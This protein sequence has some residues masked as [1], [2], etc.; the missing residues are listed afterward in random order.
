MATVL[1]S[2]G[3]NSNHTELGVASEESKWPFVTLPSFSSWAGGGVGGWNIQ[4]LR[5]LQDDI[6]SQT[7]LLTI[8]S[9][10][11]GVIVPHNQLDSWNGYSSQLA[12]KYV[13]QELNSQQSMSDSSAAHQAA[14]DAAAVSNITPYVWNYEAGDLD[15]GIHDNMGNSTEKVEDRGPASEYAVSWQSTPLQPGAINYNDLASP[16]F[17]L[18]YQAMQESSKSSLSEIILSAPI[19]SDIETTPLKPYSLLLQPIFGSIV[20]DGKKIVGYLKAVVSWEA[21][22]HGI[23]PDG[24]AGIRV[25]VDSGACRTGSLTSDEE[26]KSI[27]F[28]LDGENA[29]MLGAGDSHA[30]HGSDTLLFQTHLGSSPSSPSQSSTSSILSSV[31]EKQGCAY[32]IM[33]YST[34]EFRQGYI[35]QRPIW[36]ALVG[37]STVVLTA[38]VFALYNWLVHRR[39]QKLMDT[40]ARSHALVDSLFPAN[41]RDRLMRESGN[42]GPRRLSVPAVEFQKAV[43]TKPKSTK[44]FLL[45]ARSKRGLTSSGTP[46]TVASAM[47]YGGGVVANEDGNNLNTPGKLDIA[48]IMRSKPIADLF[49]RCTV[50][51]GEFESQAATLLQPN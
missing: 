44:N 34:E 4:R 42:F 14:V 43:D 17:Q 22:L 32:S 30:N 36:Y 33:V 12:S 26:D 9:V 24:V 2:S 11:F 29:V 35:D 3:G 51:F 28:E 49:P 48:K 18:A 31:T 39:Q 16:T 25:V 27:A 10:T 45:K 6:S 23:L 38:T 37:V 40:A 13:L 50:L 47:D 1:A 20:G 41:V 5:Q 15:T 46:T 19:H 7:T 21:M 8:E